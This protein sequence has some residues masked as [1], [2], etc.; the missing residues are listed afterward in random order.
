MNFKE[1]TKILEN[2]CQVLTILSWP[3]ISFLGFS[4]KNPEDET[5]VQYSTKLKTKK[6]CERLL[7]FINLNFPEIMFKEESK[8]AIDFNLLTQH[9][10]QY[11]DELS[12]N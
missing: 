12:E 3:Q 11:M 1:L 5:I 4:Y 10:E 9:I 6:D 8:K 7:G 2:E